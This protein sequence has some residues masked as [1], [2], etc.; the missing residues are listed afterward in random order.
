MYLP[1]ILLVVGPS[2]SSCLASLSRK[3]VGERS[4]S[5]PE[6]PPHSKKKDAA[7]MVG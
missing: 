6:M 3:V 1:Q 5:R 2:S 4:R 7:A